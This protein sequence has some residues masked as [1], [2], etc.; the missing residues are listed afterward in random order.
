MEALGYLQKYFAIF[1]LTLLLGTVLRNI[2]FQDLGS[3]F[4][5]T[6]QK[7]VNTEEANKL[8]CTSVVASLT[9]GRFSFSCLS[10]VRMT[11]SITCFSCSTFTTLTCQQVLC[12]L[13]MLYHHILEHHFK[14][15]KGIMICIKRN[16]KMMV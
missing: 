9:C 15:P 6:T 16:L 5:R 7:L 13:K 12:I 10:R 4:A 2:T 11:S 8:Y 14:K 1:L 3:I